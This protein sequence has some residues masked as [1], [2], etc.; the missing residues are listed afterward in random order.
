MNLTDEFDLKSSLD[1]SFPNLSLG[2]DLF[3]QGPFGV[4]V[5]IGL[6]HIDRA[7]TIFHAV[8]QQAKEVVLFSEDSSWEADPKRWYELFALPGL[9]RSPEVPRVRSYNVLL[10]KEEDYVVRWAVIRHS[11]LSAERLFEA[12][13]NQDHG[14]TPSVRGRVHI[15]D[16]AAGVLLHM[17]DDRGMDIIA[18]SVPPLQALK[19]SFAPWLIR[20]KLDGQNRRDQ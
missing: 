15:L 7:T 17:Y 6:T 10:S 1:R 16:P 11:A 5:D 20:E 19:N 13:A 14:L 12:I 18:T 2:G 4:K 8:F 3:F 9:L